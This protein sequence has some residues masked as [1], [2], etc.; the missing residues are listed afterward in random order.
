MI[1]G[2][3]DKTPEEVKEDLER[4]L[5]LA[6]ARIGKKKLSYE[7]LYD[8]TGFAKATLLRWRKKPGFKPREQF[9]EKLCND[10][11]VNPSYFNLH[12]TLTEEDR[13]YFDNQERGFD[14]G[15]DPAF[16]RYLKSKDDIDSMVGGMIEPTSEGY[17]EVKFQHIIPCE[18]EEII[19]DGKRIIREKAPG[20][21]E[22]RY[23]DRTTA[24]VIRVIQ[25]EVEELIRDSL[26]YYW[27]LLSVF[28]D[29]SEREKLVDYLKKRL[30]GSEKKESESRSMY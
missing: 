21:I 18:H 8:L 19:K 22:E 29:E 28:P 11:G 25:S 7:Y 27:S 4:V 9:I 10:L 16:L 3:K 23:P 5:E 2:Y 12:Q 26:S 17:G 1:Q 20:K 24:F 14:L 15:L 30:E 6:A 13:I